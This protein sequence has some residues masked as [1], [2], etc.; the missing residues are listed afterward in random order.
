[1]RDIYYFGT[2]LVDLF[3]PQAGMAGIQLLERFGA[4]VHYPQE[5]SCCGQP[6]LTAG[7]VM[8][9]RM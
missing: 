7:F 8:K 2:C 3:Y 9:R 5:Q 6:P 4:R 1:M